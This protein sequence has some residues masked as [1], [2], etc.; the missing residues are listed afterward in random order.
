M[1]AA[2]RPPLGF[3]IKVNYGLGSV[4]QATAGVALVGGIIGYYLNQVLGISPL[5]A[6]ELVLISLVVDAIA[7]PLI[8]RWSDSFRSRWGRRHPFMYASAIPIGLAL[9]F[10]WNPPHG[11]PLPQLVAFVLGAL[12]L[13]R[14][15]VSLYQIPSDSLSPELA[16]DYNERTG[17]LSFRWFFAVVAGV[18][19]IALLTIVFVPQ[20]AKHPLGMLNRE[21][22]GHFGVVAA[23][24]TAIAVLASSLATH[25]YIPY[26]QP[27][28]K[29]HIPLSQALK[30]V[31]A[32]LT[33]RSFV[34]LMI[35]GLFGWIGAGMNG[36]IGNYLNLHFWRLTPQ[37]VGVMLAALAPISVIGVFLAP[38]L[39]R[40]IDKKRTMMAVFAVSI[41]SGAIPIILRLVG[42][43]PPNGSIWVPII[44]EI[45]LAIAATLALIGFIIMSSMVADVVEDVAV[46]TGVRSEGLLFAVN[47]IIPKVTAGIGGV[48]GGLILTVVHFPMAAMP[49]TVDPEL[50]RRLA[51][52]SM[53]TGVVLGLI[54]T[55]VLIFYNIDQASHERNLETLRSMKPAGED[56]PPGR[57]LSGPDVALRT[58]GEAPVSP[59][60]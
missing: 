40:R 51:L 29:R 38:V 18:V 39:A 30:E 35:S 21:G 60:A 4:A 44:L 19:M 6:S 58:A 32:V 34:V 42:L 2:D 41:L 16:P 20:D 26:L 33:N 5:L 43:M 9:Y 7:D 28:P 11:L 47:G 27:A 36:Y 3:A 55:G 54:A 53:P 57:G 49:G 13:L 8:G 48:I 15:C 10:F 17:L 52:I 24:V 46:K 59:A 22:Y 31:S 50:L 37:V 25:R 14:V 45:D 23:I 12:I 56:G 1:S